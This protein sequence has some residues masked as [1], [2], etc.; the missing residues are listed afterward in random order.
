M[1]YVNNIPVDTQ[2]FPDNTILVKQPNLMSQPVYID[3]RFEDN[4]EL[5]TV[6]CLADHLHQNHPDVALFMPYIPNARQD[7]TKVPQ[8]VFTLK[9]FCKL[10]N[11]ANFQYVTVLDPHSHVSEALIDRIKIESPLPYIRRAISEIISKELIH[12]Q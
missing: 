1:I 11:A 2:H 6:L 8:D 4:E 9:T 12:F 5:F 7:R 10:I 3:W